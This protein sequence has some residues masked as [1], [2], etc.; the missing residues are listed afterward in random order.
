M[1]A[2]HEVRPLYGFSRT[3]ISLAS[4]QTIG[5]RQPEAPTKMIKN[6]CKTRPKPTSNLQKCNYCCSTPSEPK[7]KIQPTNPNAHMYVNGTDAERHREKNL[8]AASDGSGV[9][10]KQS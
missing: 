5:L 7:N 10:S 3:G 1:V 9:Y 2:M 6:A 8:F 4:L